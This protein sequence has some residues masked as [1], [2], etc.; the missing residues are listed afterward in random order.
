MKV[1]IQYEHAA[2]LFDNCVAKR[3]DNKLVESASRL[4]VP[5]VTF[6][7]NTTVL[8][9]NARRNCPAVLN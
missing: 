9:E 1:D 6:R 7:S 3:L 4:A 2:Q 5:F 8:S